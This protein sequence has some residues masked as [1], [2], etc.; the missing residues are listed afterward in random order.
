LA[1]LLHAVFS[2]GIGLVDRSVII[3]FAVFHS[4][5]SSISQ[6]CPEP[7]QPIAIACECRLCPCR[8]DRLVRVHCVAF[9]RSGLRVR[10][11]FNSVLLAALLCRRSLYFH[12]ARKK[13]VTV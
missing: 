3:Y 5:L 11:V 2:S 7:R 1:T 4:L 13:A 9:T 8:E 10:K 6:I 12:S